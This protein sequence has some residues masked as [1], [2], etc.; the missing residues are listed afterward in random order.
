[1]FGRKAKP[2]KVYEYGC[3]P[4]ISGKDVLIEELH[5]KQQFWNRLVEIEH[6]H[7]EKVR[8]LGIIP[9]DP[10]LSLVD[11]LNAI[12]EEI[13]T[14]RKKERSGKVD[15]TE[16]QEKARELREHIATAKTERDAVKKLIRETNK[17]GLEQLEKKRREL[18]KVAT[19]IGR[20]H[21]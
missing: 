5:R 18:V 3:L 21:V 2:C 15:V 13:K 19:E 6:A 14:A 16:L 1:M 10:V 8:E 4:P 7:R 11:K 12:R 9:D 20:A 17:T